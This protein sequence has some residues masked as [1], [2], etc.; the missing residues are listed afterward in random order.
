MHRCTFQLQSHNDKGGECSMRD[1]NGALTAR[2]WHKAFFAAPLTSRTQQAYSLACWTCTWDKLPY[3]NLKPRRTAISLTILI[4]LHVA[5][6]CDGKGYFHN[7]N[8]GLELHMSAWS[9][10][11]HLVAALIAAFLYTALR[12]WRFRT[13]RWLPGSCVMAPLHW[14]VSITCMN[15]L[16]FLEL[17]GRVAG[18]SWS[19][20]SPP[21]G[22]VHWAIFQHSFWHCQYLFQPRMS[23][24][25]SQWQLM[26]Q[27]NAQIIANTGNTVWMLKQTLL[28]R[29]Y[30]RFAVLDF[31]TTA[32]QSVRQTH[33]KKIL[34]GFQQACMQQIC[35]GFWR[36]LCKS[37]NSD[38]QNYTLWRD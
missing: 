34:S 27:Q 35:Q 7:L 23:N 31:A 15:L 2:Q 21:H 8:T 11:H 10:P 13:F 29:L 14:I 28:S 30:K 4:L 22:V 38:Y 20:N 32:L 3:Q 1:E 24:R 19:N 6:C 37:K 9:F 5:P 26:L 12:Y 16:I 33:N 18:R 17:W 36:F 25:Y